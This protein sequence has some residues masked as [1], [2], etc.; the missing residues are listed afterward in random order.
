M[1]IWTR[2]RKFVKVEPIRLGLVTRTVVTSEL[3]TTAY[4][5]SENGLATSSTVD[6]GGL[7]LTSTTTYEAPGTGFLRRTGR[8]LPAGNA[9]SDAYYGNAE[10]RANPC[11][12]ASSANQA[13]MAKLNTG[14]DPDGTGPQ[15]PR[16]EESVS[17]SSSKTRTSGTFQM[18]LSLAT[19]TDGASIRT[20]HLMTTVSTWNSTTQ[21]VP[22]SFSRIVLAQTALRPTA[23]RP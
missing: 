19:A 6:P 10:T 8:T 14:P 18:A 9:W 23:L 16:V 20:W 22:A 21:Q 3:T 7:A 4:A 13:G 5:R 12:T 15:V 1:N 2:S 11:N 17:D